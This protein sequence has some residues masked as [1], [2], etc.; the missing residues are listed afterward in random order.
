MLILP[1]ELPVYELRITDCIKQALQK[2]VICLAGAGNSGANARLAFPARLPRV[3]GIHATD[4][5]GNPSAFNPSPIKERKNFATLGEQI[6]ATGF[7]VK[8]PRDNTITGTTYT[9]TVAAGMLACWHAG[10][11]HLTGEE[12]IAAPA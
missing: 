9:I 4:S 12:H 5:L 2:S 10:I 7:P 3:V 1:F 6:R 8:D 11:R